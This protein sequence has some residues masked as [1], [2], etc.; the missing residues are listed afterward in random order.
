MTELKEMRDDAYESLRMY[1]ATR[2]AADTF[3]V[4]AF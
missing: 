2:S 4:V 1:W 3:T